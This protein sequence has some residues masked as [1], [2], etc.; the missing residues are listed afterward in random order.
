MAS[1]ILVGSLSRLYAENKKHNFTV[2]K[3]TEERLQSMIP[4]TISQEDYEKILAYA[5][6]E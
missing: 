5:E 2:N 4:Q 6:Q 3:V 1:P